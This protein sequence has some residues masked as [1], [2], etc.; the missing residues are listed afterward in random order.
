[1][2]FDQVQPGDDSGLN[3][4]HHNGQTPTVL[5]VE[6][7]DFNRLAIRLMVERLGFSTL[8][9][10]DGRQCL[11]ILKSRPVDCI[12]MDIQMPVMDGLEAT[13]RIRGQESEAG[14]LG[15]E[16]GES[17]SNLQVSGFN[18]Q[19]SRRSKIPIIALTAHA[20]VGDREKFLAAGMDDYLAKPVRMEDLEQVLRNA[21]S[22]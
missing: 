5:L 12:L 18:P 22:G 16:N 10:A 21:L 11:E 8:E 17:S 20:M 4:P 2:I 7:D 6:D 3:E 14:S 9:A 1:M 13:K 15:P 19:P